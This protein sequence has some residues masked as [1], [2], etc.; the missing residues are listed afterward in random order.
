MPGASKFV[1]QSVIC[2]KSGGGAGAL[3]SDGASKALN[4]SGATSS[5]SEVC[6]PVDDEL[7]GILATAFSCVA[8]RGVG[9]VM[10]AGVLQLTTGVPLLTVSDTSLLAV[11]K[12][13]RSDGVNSTCS[14]RVPASSNPPAAGV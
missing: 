8:L 10:F 2:V 4:I 7:P 9:Y 5:A 6:M 3:G 14:A 1:T 13:V 12:L 11:V